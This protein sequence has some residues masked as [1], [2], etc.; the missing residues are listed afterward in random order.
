MGSLPKLLSDGPV[1][2]SLSADGPSASHVPEATLRNPPRA[3]TSVLALK[4]TE[5]HHL[6]AKYIRS[7]TE[8]E[9]MT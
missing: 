2:L 7:F 4:S 1:A 5:A 9:I 6:L 8:L 3:V